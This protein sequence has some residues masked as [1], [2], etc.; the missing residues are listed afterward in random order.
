MET[1]IV[2][3][4]LT[5]EALLFTLLFFFRDVKIKAVSLIFILNIKHCMSIFNHVSISKEPKERIRTTQRETLASGK[6]GGKGLLQSRKWESVFKSTAT[7]ITRQ[8]TSFPQTCFPL[9]NIYHLK[10]FLTEQ[11]CVLF[12][13]IFVSIPELLYSSI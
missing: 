3:T 10:S 4:H 9:Q 13:D 1:I 11:P 8:H 5:R 7:W 12:S 6:W 2:R